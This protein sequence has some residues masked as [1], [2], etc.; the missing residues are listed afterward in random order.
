MR[1]K[2]CIQTLIVLFS[3]LSQFV[4]AEPT[5]PRGPVKLVVPVPPGGAADFIARIL[6]QRLS[7]ELGQSFIIENVSGATGTIAAQQVAR[8][9]P[10]GYTLLLSSSTTHG[11]APAAFKTLPYDPLSSFYHIR[12]IA[13]VPAV[14]VV[15]KELPV[16]SVAQLIDYSK[17][18]PDT[19]NYASSGNGSPLNFWG[20]MFKQ[21]TQASLS[22]I[23]YK[24]SGPAVTDL[25]AGRI[26][27]M[28]DG[29]PAQLGNIQAGNTRLLA[30]MHP[31]RLPALPDTPTMAELGCPQVIGGLWYGLSGPAG[32][33]QSVVDKLDQALIKIESSG[34]LLDQFSQRG[35]LLT[36][37]SQSQYAAFIQAENE[38]YRA[39]GLA[40][41][42]TNE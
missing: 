29:L 15:N 6:A 36:P 26:Q 30:V 42:I 33:P 23:P 5:Y 39:I 3:L 14:V 24:G 35:I 41:G 20:E 1:L 21:A 37:L 7:E 31:V 25:I 22:H 10:D 40:S 13:I 19:L 17:Q 9:K 4:Y 28:F 11:T 18:K 34:Q 2:Y 27:V 12:L 38:K 8:A 32:L 16:T